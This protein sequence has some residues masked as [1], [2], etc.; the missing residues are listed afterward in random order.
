MAHGIMEH[1]SLFVAEKKPW[2]GLGIV[3]DNPP[4]SA[5]AIRVAGLDWKVETQ[6]LFIEKNGKKHIVEN[7]FANVRSDNDDI[8]GIVSG[9]YTI[10]QNSEAFAFVDNIMSQTETP[11]RYES[12]GSL[13]NGKKVWMLARMENVKILDDEIENYLCFS[14]SHDGKGSIRC[15]L[16]NVRVVCNNTLQMSINQAKRMW[17]VRHMGTIE[18]KRLEAMQT[19]GFA[20]N[21]IKAMEKQANDMYLIK[22][23]WGKF[24]DKLMP[25]KNEA[26]DRI[27]KN[28]EFVRDT[29]NSIYNN[30]SDL[31]NIRGTAYGAYNAV[32]DFY[33]NT[34]PLR[35]APTYRERKFNEFLT[36]SSLLER[37]QDILM[38]A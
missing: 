8:L 38:A 20:T 34:A 2:H 3:L 24:L 30:K 5:E 4:T 18:G 10:C 26:S 19:L 29:L 37:A 35:N 31:G 12:A 21:Y 28:N 23:D 11:V 13:F 33:S 14:N 36:N 16:T 32:A 22:V 6:P 25:M 27:K 9:K 17:S 15:A 7:S 1:D